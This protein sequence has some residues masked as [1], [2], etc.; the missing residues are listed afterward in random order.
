MKL[1]LNEELKRLLQLSTLYDSS[2]NQIDNLKQLKTENQKH[3][4][5]V[6]HLKTSNHRQQQEIDRL[7]SHTQGD[8]MKFNSKIHD[9][10]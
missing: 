10:E 1:I 3:V 6:S 2:Q 5:M 4:Q 9:L 8:S 7:L